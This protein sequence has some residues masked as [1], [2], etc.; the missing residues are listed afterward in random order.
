M[1]KEV[2]AQMMTPEGFAPFGK[3]LIPTDD[4]ITLSNEKVRH[5]NAVGTFET[6]GRD[7]AV[8]FFTVKRRAFVLDSFERHTR[9]SEIFFPVKGTALMP[10][11]P[12]L[13]DG[14]PDTERIRVFVCGEGEP[15]T[16]E[17]GVWHLFPFPVGERYDS[18]VIVE[19]A[20]IEEDLEAVTLKEPVRIVL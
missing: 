7:P 3:L 18:Y 6:M 10:F 1:M 4:K 15:F 5:Y 16:C 2:K 13:P 11:A 20:L 14:S 8:S 12:T 19:K 17:R 9:S